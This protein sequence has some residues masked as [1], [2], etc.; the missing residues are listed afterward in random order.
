MAAKEAVNTGIKNVG[1]DARCNEVAETMLEVVKSYECEHD[2][3]TQKIIPI[4]NLCGY[5]MSR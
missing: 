5:K 3:S 2:G 4:T 1:I